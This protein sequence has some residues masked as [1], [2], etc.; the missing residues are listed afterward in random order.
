MSAER[1]RLIGSTG[2]P[3]ALKLR[4]ILRYRRLPFDW[5]LMTKALREETS[6]VRP[7][8]IPLLR[9]PAEDQY[10]TDT[11]F[12][13]HALEERHPGSRSNP[14]GR[15]GAGVYLGSAGRHGG[16]MGGQEPLPLSLA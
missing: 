14:T 16:R 4:A 3:Y 9:F 5:V 6:D 13:A 11:T 2:S 8:L 7:N 15:P 1:Y 10:R 12:L